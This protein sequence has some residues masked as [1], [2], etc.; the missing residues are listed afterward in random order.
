MVSHIYFRD[1]KS[2]DMYLGNMLSLKN[3][4]LLNIYN[5]LEVKIEQTPFCISV[6]QELLSKG[7]PLNQKEIKE[8]IKKTM[9][10]LIFVAKTVKNCHN[11]YF[12]PSDLVES[13]NEYYLRGFDYK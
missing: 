12:T 9:D 1:Q 7:N 11:L 13:N 2:L 8:D 5:T 4:C 3:I 10:L 6:H